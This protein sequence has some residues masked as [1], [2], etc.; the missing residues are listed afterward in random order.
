MNDDFTFLFFCDSGGRTNRVTLGGMV[1]RVAG[2][3]RFPN[4]PTAISLNNMLLRHTCLSVE[5]RNFLF[6]HRTRGSEQPIYP[7]RVK[8]A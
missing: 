4:R 6:A 1:R 5:F 3:A 2:S 8:D 7:T